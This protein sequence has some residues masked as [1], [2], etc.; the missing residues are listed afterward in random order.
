MQDYYLLLLDKFISYDMII[1]YVSLYQSICQYGILV[2]GG[3]TAD[4]ILKPLIAQQNNA[5][6]ICLDKKK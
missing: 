1:E 5:I 4:N 6:R 3:G 2:W